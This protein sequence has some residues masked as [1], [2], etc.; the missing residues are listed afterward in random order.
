[1]DF[2]P[3]TKKKFN[4]MNPRIWHIPLEWLGTYMRK[5]EED[6]IFTNLGRI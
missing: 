5:A 3:F 1:V 2:Y 6:R 4:L